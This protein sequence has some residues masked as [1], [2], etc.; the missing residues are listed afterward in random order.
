[1]E[2]ELL[3]K[4]KYN[5]HDDLAVNPDGSVKLKHNSPYC[6]TRITAYNELGEMLFDTENQVVL[7]GALFTLEKVFGIQ[8][9]L[10][11]EYLNNI[12]SIATT[13]TPVTEIYPKDNVVCLFGIGIG[14]CGESYKT[15][16]D[17]KFYER[18]IEDMIPFR[19]VTGDL[20]EAIAPK[21]FFKT[22][23]AGKNAFYLKKFEQTPQ[24]KVLWKDAEGDEDGSEVQEGVH[25]TTRTEAIETFVE[26]TLKI[27]KDDVRE[28]FDING[29]IEQ[30]RINSIALFTGVKS[31]LADGSEDYKQVKMF[32]KLNI[33]NEMLAISKSFTMVYRIYTS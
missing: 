2:Q 3:L 29:N 10:N 24:I 28:Y 11:V 31:L 23:Y 25:N 30:A 22:Q 6:R 18:T 15:V 27:D 4:D 13:G 1:M 8:S 7:G 20:P 16:K 5:C 21:Y 17:V 33:P 32:S 26:I 9:P 12:M 19:V 14:G